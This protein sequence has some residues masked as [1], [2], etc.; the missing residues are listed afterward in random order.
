M[1]EQI[2]EK[3]IKE[4][5]RRFSSTRTREAVVFEVRIVSHNQPRY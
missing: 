2:K 3:K 4:E 5:I 1:S